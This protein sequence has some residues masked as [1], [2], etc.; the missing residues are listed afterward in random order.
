MG[1]G[2]GWLRIRLIE[3]GD[4]GDFDGAA[5][6]ELSDKQTFCYTAPVGGA[7][8]ADFGFAVGRFL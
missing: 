7:A 6:G 3:H 5:T 4:F 8:D 1:C 2:G